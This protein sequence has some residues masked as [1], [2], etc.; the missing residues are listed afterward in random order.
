MS[1]KRRPTRS[2]W[3]VGLPRSAIPA[4]ASTIQRKSSGRRE[5]IIAIASGPRNSTVTTTPSGAPSIAS[6]KHVFMT[7]SVSPSAITQRSGPARTRRRTPGSRAIR[8]SAPN[9]ER[10]QTTGR[11]PTRSKSPVAI[12]APLCTEKAAATTRS[13]AGSRPIAGP[14]R[15]AR[16]ERVTAATEG[17]YV[18]VGRLKLVDV[19]EAVDLHRT[20]RTATGVFRRRAVEVAAVRGVSF[21]VGRGE[22]FGLLG[23]NGAGKTTTIKMLITLLLPTSGSARVLGYD[24]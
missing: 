10:N 7:A 23:P 20:Y 14:T 17:S 9:A 16:V 5:P 19:I 12:A 13:G 6:K 4:A 22:L 1:A 21:S 18:R 3:T 2:T 8:T 15:R 24:V 11:G